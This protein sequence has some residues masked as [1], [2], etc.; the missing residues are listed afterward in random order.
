LCGNSVAPEPFAA[1]IRAN[2]NKEAK[3]QEQAA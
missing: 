3:E 1:L 2:I